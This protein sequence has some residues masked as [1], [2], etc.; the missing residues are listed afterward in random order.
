MVHTGS[1]EV[2]GAR[3]GRDS[4]GV[5][6]AVAMVVGLDSFTLVGG[7]IVVG[8]TLVSVV[9]ASVAVGVEKSVTAWAAC[10][11][12]VTLFADVLETEF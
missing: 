6:V 3:K 8:F 1:G 7:V 5:V 10:A 2:L 12:A 4:L 11:L 9:A